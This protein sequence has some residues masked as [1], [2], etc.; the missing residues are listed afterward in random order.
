MLEPRRIARPAAVQPAGPGG[1]RHRWTLAALASFWIAS[2]LGYYFV[3]PAIGR[4]PDYNA[5][6]IAISIYYL[7]WVGLTVIAF[8][9]VYA[10][11]N[12]HAPWPTFRN[13][14]ASTTIWVLLYGGAV[15]FAAFVVPTI[16]P[17]L[18]PAALGPAPDLIVATERYF[19]PK[20]I[21]IVFQQLLI[22]ALVLGLAA[23]GLRL[24]TISLACA[25]LFGGMHVLLIL[26]DMPI[27][28]VARFTVLAAVFGA[29]APTL[30]LRVPY[31]LAI[32][33]GLHWSYY[34]LT[35]LQLRFFG[36]QAALET[37]TGG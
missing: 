11:W 4:V 19:L 22:L 3:L 10:V 9:P 20:S 12:V 14:L 25:A 32:A 33:F 16:P 17:A 30:L 31:G 35:L 26:G 27:T 6:P 8:W 24:R 5:D 37:L 15:A 23:D 34:A 36:P 18:W 1:A 13:R 2:D 29:V 21:E 7:F 28:A